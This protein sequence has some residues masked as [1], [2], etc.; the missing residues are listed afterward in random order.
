M[1][2][3]GTFQVFVALHRSPTEDPGSACFISGGSGPRAYRFEPATWSGSKNIPKRPS[4]T[5][6][7]REEAR[8]SAP[9]VCTVQSRLRHWLEG[10]PLPWRGK[11]SSGAD[12]SQIDRSHRSI[13][14]PTEGPILRPLT[15]ARTEPTSAHGRTTSLM[16]RAIRVKCVLSSLR[17]CVRLCAYSAYIHVPSTIHCATER[18]LQTPP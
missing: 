18:P 14:R 10:G 16:A 9:S 5:P 4:G 3:S 1:I 6:G 8:S 2:G 15:H 17:E 11:C 13:H 7:A 12:I